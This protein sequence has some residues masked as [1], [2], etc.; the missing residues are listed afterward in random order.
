ME[1]E[2]NKNKKKVGRKP[3]T[4]KAKHK[5][6]FRL[7]AEENAK[8]LALF[9]ASGM[10]NKSKFLVSLLFRKEQ[11]WRYCV[12]KSSNLPKIGEKSST[13]AI[14]PVLRNWF[15]KKLDTLPI[16]VQFFI[17]FDKSVQTS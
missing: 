4:V 3:K 10:P 13:G 11:K 16:Q 12:K 2:L 8:F 14:K 6:M 15:L 1:N 5:Y 17:T 9:E 7:T